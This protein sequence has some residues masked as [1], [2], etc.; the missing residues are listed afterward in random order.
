MT[1]LRT[2]LAC[3]KAADADIMAFAFRTDVP[4]FR[5]GYDHH[6]RAW[7][8]AMCR[9]TWI[10]YHTRREFRDSYDARQR[11]MRELPLPAW[12]EVA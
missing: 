12:K 6:V 10:R 11:A 5:M 9:E 8:N 3:L 1:R 2:Q 4:V 7:K